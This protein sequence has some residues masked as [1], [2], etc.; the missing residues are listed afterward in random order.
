MVGVV[1]GVTMGVAV[2]C[3]RT[4]GEDVMSTGGSVSVAD[5]GG[6]GWKGC[7]RF[8]DGISGELSEDLSYRLPLTL[9]ISE[10]CS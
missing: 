7:C 2:G 10:V 8:H 5:G 1:C 6:T 4:R 9:N 3:V